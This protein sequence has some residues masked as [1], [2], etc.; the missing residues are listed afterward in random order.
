[1]PSLIDSQPVSKI[2][3]MHR[4]LH[5]PNSYNPNCVAPPE[6]TLL[7]LSILDDG[8]TTPIVTLPELD[9]IFQIVD[10]FHRWKWLK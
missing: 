3:W 2:I 6:L 10:G 1:M 9:G 4:D 8:W 7:K 5:E